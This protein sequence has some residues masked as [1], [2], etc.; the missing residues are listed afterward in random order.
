MIGAL[1]RRPVFP[2]IR[3]AFTARK[4]AIHA[5]IL[6]AGHGRS[7]RPCSTSST[8][9]NRGGAQTTRPS[10]LL[11]LGNASSPITT[12]TPELAGVGALNLTTAQNLLANLSGNI[13]QITEQYW[14]NSPTQKD[15]SNYTSDFL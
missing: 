13:A 15:W 9:L 12:A 4:F 5:F 1:P 2:I 6:P 14:V 8:S 11:G 3:P 7:R 10:V